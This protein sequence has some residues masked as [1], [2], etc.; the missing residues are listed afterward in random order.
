MK[1]ILLDNYDSFTYNLVHVIK[2]VLTTGDQLEVAKNDQ[3]DLS[4][5]DDYDKIIISPGPGLPKEAGC[6]LPLIERWGHLKPVLGICL[7]HQ[8]LGQ[9]YG[10]KLRRLRNVSHGI[11]SRVDLVKRSYLFDNL[12]DKIKVGRYHSW[13]IDCDDFPE[14]LEITAL[15]EDGLI[16]GICHKEHDAHGIQF[17]PESIM[18]PTGKTI[19]T[20]FLYRG[21][22]A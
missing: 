10:A 1:V 8:A 18:T 19:I 21:G 7:G 5:L 20:H 13:C 22:E 9:V 3:I 11:Q 14:T 6:L 12:G 15:T 4:Q 17:H 2:E 16:M